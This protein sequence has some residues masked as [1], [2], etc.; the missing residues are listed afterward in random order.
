[1]WVSIS[2]LVSVPIIFYVANQFLMLALES[3]GLP[4]KPRDISWAMITSSMI[5]GLGWF[6]ISHIIINAITSLNPIATLNTRIKEMGE[7][8]GIKR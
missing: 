8:S 4:V 3:K 1:M 7:R 2:A 5:S 6:L